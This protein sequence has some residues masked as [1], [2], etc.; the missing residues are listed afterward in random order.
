MAIFAAMPL[1]SLTGSELT[2]SAS[3]EAGSSDRDWTPVS[4]DLSVSPSP[5]ARSVRVTSAGV[6]ALAQLERLSPELVRVWW[7]VT[8]LPATQERVYSIT[9]LEE[10][11]AETKFRQEDTS[12]GVDRST[13]L[14]FE[15]RPALRYVHRP[16]DPDE[17]EETKKPFHHVFDVEGTGFITKGVGGLY[18]H[19]RGIFFGYRRCRVEGEVLDTWHARDGEHQDHEAF[20]AV[21]VGDVFGGHT[22]RISW[23]DRQGQ[24]FLREFRRVRVFA[25]PDGQ[26][27]I[28]LTSTLEAVDGPVEL[29]GDRQ[30]AG[31]QFRAAQEVAD[32]DDETRFLRPASWAH[33]PADREVNSD[34]HRGLP[35]NA[36]QFEARGRAYTVAYLSHPDN[37]GEAEFSERLYGRF[38]E[39]FPGEVRAGSPL[40]LRYRFWVQADGSV[41]RS[42]IERKH[43][44]FT[45][46]PGVRLLEELFI[47]GD[48]NDDGGVDLSDSLK[49]LQVLFLPGSVDAIPACYRALDANDDGSLDIADPVFTLLGLFTAGFGDPPPPFPACGEDPTPDELSC[50]RASSCPEG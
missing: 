36:I 8:D 5:D 47:R 49:M 44:D 31:V 12:V 14:L 2:F 27:L 45:R 18:S 21:H 23:N 41:Q 40:T 46:P 9:L 34:D 30:H 7:I 33:L 43:A 10:D 32:H 26:R 48:A 16:F 11:A 17:I 20:E 42:E 38:G 28:E 4:L 13:D 25:Q 37:S 50:A 6:P 1:S 35:W 19:H 3:V 22:A 24:A 39:F 29:D 15:G